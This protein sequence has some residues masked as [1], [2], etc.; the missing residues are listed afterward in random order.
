MSQPRLCLIT[1]ANAGIGKVTA[2]ELAQKGFDI[3][4]LCRNLDKAR[5][6]RAEIKAVSKTGVVDLLPCDLASLAAVRQAAREVADRYDHLD[7]LVNN[8]GLYIEKRQTSP[9]GYEL[10]FATNHLGP[11]LLTNLLLPLLRKGTKPRIVNVASEA[12]RFARHFRLDKLANPKKYDGMA[13]YGASKLCNI[14]FT[15]ELATRLMGDGI[16][17][18]AVHPGLVNSNFGSGSTNLTGLIF[19]VM[20]LF[21]RSPEKGAETSIYLAA[22]PAVTDVTGLYFADCQ[23]KMPNADAT[24]DF[25]AKR[26]WEISEEMTRLK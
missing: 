10:T 2:L 16:T 7:V 1:G 3:I 4:M 15:K 11:F 5:P 26:L 9:D 23:P 13:V 17:V 14:L 18:N 6:V 20:K 24:N 22:S 19:G 8:A 12:H 21:G 25:N